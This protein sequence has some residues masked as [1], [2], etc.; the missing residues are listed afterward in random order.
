MRHLLAKD[1]RL[2]AP[3]LWLVVPVHALYSIQAFLSP[4]LYFWMNLSAALAWTVSV[5]AIEWHLDADHLVGSLPVTRAAIV[6][7]RYASAFGGLVIGAALF[8]LYGHLTMAVAT[9]RVAERWPGSP[10]W[11][12]ADGVVAFLAVGYVLLVSFLPFFFRWGLPIGAALFSASAA[13][14]LSA[15]TMLAR[16][17]SQAVPAAQVP[18]GI[19]D[20]LSWSEA[21]RGWLLA[22]SASRGPW[23]ASLIVL[24]GAAALGV[25]SLGLSIRAYEVRDL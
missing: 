8:V 7:A 3:Y 23:A 2:V 11:A 24:L 1:V 17:A 5:T 21:V 20:A 15:G 12:S 19:P 22:L 16:A 18:A 13:V 4:E 14:V 25:T 9:A 6:A 10:S